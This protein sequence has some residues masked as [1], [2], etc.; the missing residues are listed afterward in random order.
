MLLLPHSLS[1]TRATCAVALVGITQGAELDLAGYLIARYFGVAD[2]AA[3]FGLTILTIGLASAGSQMAFAFLF[4]RMG[5]YELPLQ[6][7]VAAFALA[8][9]GFLALGRYPAR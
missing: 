7:S 2:F 9:A 3:I 1:L 5:G 8:G 4:D 6:L